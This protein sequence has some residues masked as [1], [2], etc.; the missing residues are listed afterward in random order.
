M[1]LGKIKADTLEHST[2][3]SL[4]TSYVVRG[5]AKVWINFNGTGT[6]AIRDSFNV[7]GLTDSGTGKY[8]PAYS[9]NMSNAVYC[10]TACADTPSAVV[11]GVHIPQTADSN[12]TSGQC[13][14]GCTNFSGSSTDMS[15]YSYLVQGDLA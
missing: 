15:Q 8:T 11:G 14:I 3:G 7:S 6:V 10:A 4:D 9:N 5:S 2:A 13:Q 12:K 1:S